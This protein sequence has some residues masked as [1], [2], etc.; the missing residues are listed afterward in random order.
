MSVQIYTVRALDEFGRLY[1]HSYAFGRYDDLTNIEG[2][3][4]LIMQKLVWQILKRM[5]EDAYAEW[6]C[7]PVRDWYFEGEQENQHHE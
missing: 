2:I 7:L 6:D 4:G 3:A 1:N 5:G